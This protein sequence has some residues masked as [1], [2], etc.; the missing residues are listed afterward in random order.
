MLNMAGLHSMAF[1][2]ANKRWRRMKMAVL[3]EKTVPSNGNLRLMEKLNDDLKYDENWEKVVRADAVCFKNASL[4]LFHSQGNNYALKIQKGTPIKTSVEEIELAYEDQVTLNAHGA[5]N[6]RLFYSLQQNSAK[7]E[8]IMRQQARIKELEKELA[9]RPP[10]VVSA[11]PVKE[12]FNWRG[13]GWIVAVVLLAFLFKTAEAHPTD[14]RQPV[15]GCYVE[16]GFGRELSYD[17]LTNMCYGRTTTIL[18][19]GNVNETNLIQSCVVSLQK[20]H[21]ETLESSWY[22]TYCRD[23]I[24][25]RLHYVECTNRPIRASILNYLR[26]IIYEVQTT[27]VTYVLNLMS[28]IS[29]AVL[30]LREAKIFPA[31]C[32]YAIALLIETPPFCALVGSA[33]FPPETIL[34]QLIDGLAE[35]MGYQITLWL[36]ILNWFILVLTAFFSKGD[37]CVNVSQAVM[38]SVALPIWFL[39]RWLIAS[40][41]IPTFT[42]IVLFVCG[43]TFWIGF[44]YANVTVTVTE[45][46]GTVKKYTRAAQV[47]KNFRQKFLQV[48]SAIRGVIPAIP[49]RTDAVVKIESSFAT[50]V[51]FRYMNFLYTIGH[52]VGEDTVVNVY[53]NKVSTK[54][55]VIK[56]IP[57]IDSCD[58]LVVL[59]LPPEM[60]VMKPLRLTKQPQSD[61]MALYAL[62]QVGVAQIYSGWVEV[63]GFWLS[64]TFETQP[65]VSGGP[66]VDRHGR[67]VGIHIGTQGVCSQG[68]NLFDVMKSQT[69]EP[70][71]VVLQQ[72]STDTD[73]IVRRVID[74]TR[75]SHA[76]LTSQIEKLLERVAELEKK[77]QEK[78]ISKQ[79]TPLVEE[80]RKKIDNMKNKFMKMK[81]LTEEQYAE[82]LEKGWNADEIQQAINELREQAWLNYEIDAE[83]YDMSDEEVE[84]RIRNELD[85]LYRE[86]GPK[87]LFSAKTFIIC[88]ARRRKKK[89]VLPTENQTQALNAQTSAEPKPQ[90]E[91]KNLK[92]GRRGPQ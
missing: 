30:A 44:K 74:G 7:A 25:N 48:Q 82:M 77:L 78:D 1:S 84:E 15:D 52:V 54:T 8:L 16:P 20:M 57:L 86:M 3:L 45:P 53:W 26:S 47:R 51:G 66:Y 10:I 28:W 18:S 56:R 50:G 88:E 46:D 91:R 12:R 5:R 65:G 9:K 38:L 27:Q 49:D 70:P 33:I 72:Q 76:V 13:I 34:I 32:Y 90:R 41:E 61:Y 35:N 31:I 23:M 71:S 75:V 6:L 14:C 59:R 39:T 2:S 42:Q 37:M 29:L 36:C 64:N 79:E 87:T 58:E 4:V 43:L 17:E 73:E 40:Y 11:E 22:V 69:F 63:D 67:L 89:P 19:S 83:D 21:F 81:V 60:Q 80:K 68:Y 85:Q 62:D 55:K 24:K 92:W